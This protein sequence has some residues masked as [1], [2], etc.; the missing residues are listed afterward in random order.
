M[1]GSNES[2][3]PSSPLRKPGRFELLSGNMA[4]LSNS[5]SLSAALTDPYADLGIPPVINACGIYTD[6]GGSTLA[7]DLWGALGSVNGRWASLPELLDR[8]G[9]RIASLI[10]VEAARVVPGASA[11]IALS[12]AACIASE[13][14]SLIETLPLSQSRP[15][16]VLEQVVHRYKY[17]R[18]ALLGGAVIREV[19]TESGTRTDELREALAREDV[20]AVLHPA[21]L[22][23]VEGGVRLEEVAKLAHERAV[24]VI[25]D[26]AY[27]VFP[28]DLIGS[29][30]NRGADLTCISAKY[31]FGPNAG[32][33]IA[34]RRDLVERARTLDFTEFEGGRFR[35]FGRG[36][37]MDRTAV[38]ATTLALQSWF[39]CD[40]NER[41][42]GYARRV[43]FLRSELGSHG[44]GGDARAC[45]FTLDERVID[46]PVNSVFL[47][48]ADPRAV[49]QQL[50]TGTPAVRCVDLVDGLLFCVECVADDELGGIVDAFAAV[51]DQEP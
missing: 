44:L 34:G 5:N 49:A 29:F 14:D 12:V 22:D 31:Y 10:D 15:C 8:S 4:N 41:L 40:H 46:E 47:P 35:T 1:R 16:A 39:E 26:A 51:V 11:A 21:H 27:Q 25:V 23:E 45:C 43:D 28:V 17:T 37:K 9:E 19:G 18:C 33:F 48:V 42:A 32:G 7:P 24:P 6:L 13:D 3:Q 2:A 30:D 20:V 50:A 36:F 38:V